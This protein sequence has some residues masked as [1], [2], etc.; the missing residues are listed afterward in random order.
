M[1]EATIEIRATVD[2]AADGTFWC[3]T[4]ASINDCALSGCGDT[5]KAAIDDMNYAYAELKEMNDADGIAT[6][7]VKFAY[8]FDVAS[9]FA[10]FD[11]IN[12][13][14]IAERIGINATLLRR[15]INGKAVPGAEQRKKIGSAMKEIASEMELCEI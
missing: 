15:Y 1:N 10:C 3:Y 8:H 11:F 14:K 4:N 5:P 2:R 9:Y 6:P 7:D 12:V 13:N